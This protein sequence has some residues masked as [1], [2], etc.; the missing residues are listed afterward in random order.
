M[1]HLPYLFW[2]A[3]YRPE[4]DLLVYLG[5][6]LR[7]IAY[8]MVIYGLL[9]G[10]LV[11]L[12]GLVLLAV[13][14]WTALRPS[15]RTCFAV[16]MG[17]VLAITLGASAAARLSSGDTG[18]TFSWLV[19]AVA[20]GVG[21]LVAVLLELTVRRWQRTRLGRRLFRLHTLRRAAFFLYAL[22]LLAIL[23]VGLYRLGRDLPL[24]HPAGRPTTPDR[25]NVVLIG[26]DALRPDHLGAY[27]YDLNTSPH[28]DALAREGV[29]FQQ[30]Y[31]QSSWTLPSVSSFITS[32]YP[33]ELQIHCRQDLALCFRQIDPLRT[34][35]AEVMQAAG[36]RAHAYLSSIWLQPQDGFLQG[37]Q[38]AGFVW[39]PAPFDQA[40]LAQRPLLRTVLLYQPLRTA[41]E[42]GYELLFDPRLVPA[43]R[44]DLVNHYALRFLRRRP[45]EP[46][47]LWLYYMEPH[48][49]YNPDRPFRPLPAEITPER[50]RFLRELG[51][52]LLEA[53]SPPNLTSEEQQALLSLYDGNIAE[54]DRLIGQILAELERQGLRERTLVVI[55]ADHGEEFYD[56]GGYAHGGTLY[57]ETLHVPLIFSGPPVTTPGRV[58]ETPVRSLD[59]LPTLAEAIGQAPPA[60]A[61]GRS[62]L[63]FL[64]GEDLEALPLYSEDVY[65]PPYDLKAVRYRNYKLIYS[66]SLQQFE[67][68]NLE[69]DPG[70]QVD[71]SQT[72]PQQ[73]AELMALLED[74]QAQ[75]FLA[76]QTL[77]RVAPPQGQDSGG[78][79]EL[80]KEGGY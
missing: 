17:W 56:H 60:E 23:L 66:P 27:G 7:A 55:L 13:I 33:S 29:L 30:A 63:P 70:E 20:A 10:L 62:L 19:I 4:W 43:N 8:M 14:R 74:W 65:R 68:Y 78:F 42:A 21:G 36:Y 80:L 49:P 54:V 26:I 40:F 67:L 28:L 12:G 51:D 71:V 75:T 59:L 15:G 31:A 64:Q 2:G 46:F 72:E 25:P 76:A 48:A 32:L 38:E 77:P 34:T 5:L 35:I 57:G 1:E 22:P 73:L 79:R 58:V 69:R 24:F 41:F 37:V 9:C 3:L 53:A 52:A 6:H 50:E 11:W 44:G 18:P 39:A 61:R 47:F 45:S 16:L